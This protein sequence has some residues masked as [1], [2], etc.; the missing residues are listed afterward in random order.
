MPA[1]L[2]AAAPRSPLL[3]ARSPAR[4]P[5]DQP[6]QA[7]VRRLRGSCLEAATVLCL[8]RPRR[9][10]AQHARRRPRLRPLLWRR[11]AAC[12]EPLQCLHLLLMQQALPAPGQQPPPAA[13]HALNGR[14]GGGGPRPRDG[15]CC[16]QQH[17]LT[18]PAPPGPPPVLP[19][20]SDR[21]PRPVPPSP[22][23][24]LP[25]PS[26]RSP[27]PAHGGPPHGAVLLLELHQRRLQ[28]AVGGPARQHA[29]DGAG[30]GLAGTRARPRVRAGGA[31]CLPACMPQ[32]LPRACCRPARGACHPAVVVCIQSNLP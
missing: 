7:R 29:R 17:N 20:P 28:L 26:A 6:G 30:G 15:G 2:T 9:R 3:A 1:R 4:T 23:P 11:A 5:V 31:R 32:S 22:P 19:T 16:P 14:A 27:R 25:P 10:G 12:A 18:T 8:R 21:S 24:L 13:Q